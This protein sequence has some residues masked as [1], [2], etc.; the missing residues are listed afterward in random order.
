MSGTNEKTHIQ[1]KTS[2]DSGVFSDKVS[3]EASDFFWDL[4]LCVELRLSWRIQILL[5]VGQ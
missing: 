3:L 4:E 5:L 2:I 1:F